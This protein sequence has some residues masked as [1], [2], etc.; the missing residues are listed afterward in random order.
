MVGCTTLFHVY[1]HDAYFL[2]CFVYTLCNTAC[3]TG[4]AFYAVVHAKMIAVEEPAS[5]YQRPILDPRE[6]PPQVLKDVF[7]HFQKLHPGT[8]DSDPGILDFD[9]DISLHALELC[10]ELSAETLARVYQEFMGLDVNLPNLNAS[11]IYSSKGLP[12]RSIS[13]SLFVYAGCTCIY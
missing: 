9:K 6:P 4:S 2:I 1:I 8:I 3:F 7:K 10:D 11:P 12:G 13:F 5:Q